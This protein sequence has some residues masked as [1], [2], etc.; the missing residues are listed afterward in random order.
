MALAEFARPVLYPFYKEIDGR[1]QFV[2]EMYHWEISD[3]DGTHITVG[4][5]GVTLP[6]NKKDFV[7]YNDF[8]AEAEK[9]TL[10]LK[11][12]WRGSVIRLNC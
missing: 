1:K 4:I 2:S 8:Y 11:N 9:A 7:R 6:I 10:D 12:T 3:A 5:F